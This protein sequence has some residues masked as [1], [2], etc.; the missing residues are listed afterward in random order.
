MG[1]V[2]Q[3]R[4][5]D[6]RWVRARTDGGRDVRRDTVERRR[7]DV[8]RI[9]VIE[10]HGDAERARD[11]IGERDCACADRERSRRER[12]RA[13]RRQRGCRD[14]VAV[15]VGDR[16]QDD[17]RIRGRAERG[18]Q[19]PCGAG[20]LERGSE[21][22]RAVAGGRKQLGDEQLCR[23][24]VSERDCG[25]VVH[26]ASRQDRARARREERKPWNGVGVVEQCAEQGRGRRV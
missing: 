8:V 3:R 15:V 23:D 12:A 26:R 20:E 6:G 21:L 16:S 25:S 17:G 24:R 11:R 1:L 5:Q 2:K 10:R 22:Q 4:V 7:G 13:S 9:C 19:Q 18:E 14:R